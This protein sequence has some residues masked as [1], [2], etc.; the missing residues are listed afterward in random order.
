MRN[1]SVNT[2][3]SIDKLLKQFI[4]NPRIWS[5]IVVTDPISHVDIWFICYYNTTDVFIFNKKFINIFEI[6]LYNPDVFVYFRKN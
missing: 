1:N 3:V 6:I 5:S 4:S 2:I